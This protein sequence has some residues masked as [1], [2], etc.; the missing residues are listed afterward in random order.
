M[1]QIFKQLVIVGVLMVGVGLHGFAAGSGPTVT[2]QA[3]VLLKQAYMAVVDAELAKAEQHDAEAIKAYQAAIGFYERLKAEYPG[4]QASMVSLRQTEC[5]NALAALERPRIQDPDSDKAVASGTKAASNTVVRLQ[6]LLKELRDVQVELAKVKTYGDEM[7][8]KQ[9]MADMERLQDE[10]SDSSKEN[11]NL[12]RKI[13]KLEAKLSKSGAR[14]SG[15]NSPNRAVVAAV[16][17]EA[18]Q[19]MKANEII[20]ATTLLMEAIDLMPTES[21]LVVLLAVAHCRNGR[22]AEAIEILKPFDVW[23][24]KNADALMTMGSAYMGL[25]RIGDA[26]EATEKAVSIRPDS[27]D[28]H[29]NLAQILISL[30]PPDAAEAQEHYQRALELG[31]PVDLEFESSLRTA[32]IINRMKKR[33]TSSSAKKTTEPRALNSEVM[34]PGAKTDTP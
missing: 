4:W 28:A 17:T 6:G 26:R 1:K 20:P 15:T 19:L 10:L 14:G 27:A 31:S 25:G 32:M 24:P 22:F 29:Y 33:D 2:P 13:V 12:Q 18:N 5:L 9:L 7:R 21:D 11:I 16:K 34:T 8:V 30:V 23:R 3:G